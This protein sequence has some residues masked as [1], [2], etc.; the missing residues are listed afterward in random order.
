MI[1]DE[2]DPVDPDTQKPGEG[3]G[4]QRAIHRRLS[5]QGVQGN[6]TGTDIGTAYPCGQYSEGTSACQ[7]VPPAG[8]GHSKIDSGC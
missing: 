3:E 7:G 6:A 8:Q 2:A 5:S 1:E 4:S